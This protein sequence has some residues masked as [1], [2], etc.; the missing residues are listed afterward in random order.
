MMGFEKWHFSMFFSN[1]GYFEV[2]QTSRIF[3]G[4]VQFSFPFKQ[5]ELLFE[6]RVPGSAPWST[7]KL[8][9]IAP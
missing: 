7:G 2:C 4:V 1:M 6:K 5:W 3:R 9:D 8:A